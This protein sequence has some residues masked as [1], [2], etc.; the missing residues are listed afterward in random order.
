M[1]SEIS[2]RVLV[3]GAGLGGLCLAQGLRQAGVSVS[4]YERDATPLVRKQGYRIHIDARGASSLYA[5]LPPHLWSLFT[6]TTS[7]PSHE[8]TIAN[9]NLKPRRVIRLPEVVADG[10]GRL[11][12]AVD[13][14]TLREILMV[15]L[16]EELHFNKEFSHYQQGDDGSVRA[17]FA[18]GS[19]VVGDVLVAADGVNSRVRQQFLPA[20]RVVDSGVRCIYGKTLLTEETRPLVPEFFQKGFVVAI[21]GMFQR[22]NMALGLVEF[23]QEPVHAAAQLV[24][25]IQLHASGDYLM[26][27]LNIPR[28]E[29]ALSDEELRWMDGAALQHIVL[30]RLKRW[31]PRLRALIAAG[32]PQETFPIVVRT[33]VPYDPW[34]GSTIT[35]LGDAMH[36]MSPAGG[37]GANMALLDACL[38]CQT[39]TS[40]ARGEKDLVPALH[41]YEAQMLKTGFDAVRFSARGGVLS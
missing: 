30:A 11:S 33:S 29:L 3:I 39:L 28:A 27:S 14:L 38:L 15:G 25:A 26:W 6:A 21:G 18:D 22:F 16:D 10:Q 41:T 2:P 24:P 8:I 5:C 35:L 7:R 20:A 13:R 19:E 9:K 1:L 40:V 36:A 4:I 34:P 12:A 23:L 31:S 17:C 32:D 37:S